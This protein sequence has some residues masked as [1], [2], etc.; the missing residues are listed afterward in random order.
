MSAP[1]VK[2]GSALLS[3]FSLGQNAMGFGL[4]PAGDPPALGTSLGTGT[5]ATPTSSWAL[6]TS[7]S[8]LPSRV[9]TIIRIL[10]VR[11]LRL[12]EVK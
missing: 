8:Q 2:D 10:P 5:A 1:P 4:V 9:G 11:K 3:L 7:F 12:R 6:L